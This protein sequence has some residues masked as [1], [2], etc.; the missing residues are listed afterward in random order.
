MSINAAIIPKRQIELELMA[1]L[2]ETKAQLARTEAA[3]DVA[4]ELLVCDV[5]Q[6]VRAIQKGEE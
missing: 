5:E 1:E 6:E 2:E 4:C 3:L